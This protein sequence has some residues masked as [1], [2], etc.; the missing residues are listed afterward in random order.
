MNRFENEVLHLLDI[1][2]SPIVKKIY[3]ENTCTR[4]YVNFGS[5]ISLESQNQVDSKSCYKSITDI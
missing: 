4:Q 5:Y 2:T 1:K 3:Q